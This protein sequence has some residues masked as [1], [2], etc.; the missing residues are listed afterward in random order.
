M[1]R[2]IFAGW[3]AFHLPEEQQARQ[4]IRSEG[5]NVYVETEQGKTFGLQLSFDDDPAWV[6]VEDIYQALDAQQMI[7]GGWCGEMHMRENLIMRPLLRKKV[8]TIYCIY[9]KHPEHYGELVFAIDSRGGVWRWKMENPGLGGVLWYPVC[10][11][12]GILIGSALGYLVST[13][14]R[15]GKDEETPEVH[16]IN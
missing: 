11:L 15:W 4:F 3:K 12:M 8:D 1:Y 5:E 10:V 13:R 16:Y 7:G 6:E 2:G 14:I 9:F